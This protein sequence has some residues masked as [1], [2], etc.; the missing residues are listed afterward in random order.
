MEKIKIM[1]RDRSPIEKK[2]ALYSV[3]GQCEPE[4]KKHQEIPPITSK[5]TKLPGGL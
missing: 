3:L 2:R 5:Y 4:M 1:V